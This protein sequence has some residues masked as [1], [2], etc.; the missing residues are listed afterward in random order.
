MSWPT[1][2]WQLT[3]HVQKVMVKDHSVQ[4]LEWKQTDGQIDGQTDGG[5]C[6]TSH[7]NEVGK[8]NT[9]KAN[10]IINKATER[11]RQNKTNREPVDGVADVVSESSQLSSIRV[12]SKSVLKQLTE[13][14]RQVCRQRIHVRQRTVCTVTTICQLQI[15]H[16]TASNNTKPPLGYVHYFHFL[17]TTYNF[18][19]LQT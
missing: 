10:I 11:Q 14:V 13:H 5:D 2:T 17:T 9:N 16:T 6:I 8:N 4:K 18:T 12:L 3:E 1:H 19:L 7:S 15:F